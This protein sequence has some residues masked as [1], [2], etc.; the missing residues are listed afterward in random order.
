MGVEENAASLRRHLRNY[1]KASTIHGLN[2]IANESKIWVKLLWT[3][4]ICS[5]LT[6]FYLSISSS[7]NMWDEFPTMT[8]VESINRRVRHAN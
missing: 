1:F 6:L 5:G 3:G 2:Y 8:T 7:L 4:I